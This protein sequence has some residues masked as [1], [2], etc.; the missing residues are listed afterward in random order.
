MEGD[1]TLIRKVA[2]LVLIALAGSGCVDPGPVVPEPM[3]FPVAVSPAGDEPVA[4]NQT[5]SITFNTYVDEAPLT[6]Y[7]VAALS[8]GGVRAF[9]PTR[10]SMVDKSLILQTSRD[11]EPELLWQLDLNPEVLFSVTGQP[12]AGPT[13]VTF[14]VGE[15]REVR[16]E[17]TSVPTWSDVE[18]ILGPCND[19]HAA[20]QWQ[21]TPIT[22][23]GM[24]GVASAQVEHRQIVEAYEPSRSYLMFKLL[25]DYPLRE[26]EHQPPA[27]SD[28][29]A[30]SADELRLVEGWIRAGARP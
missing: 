8:S 25:A 28:M 19:C 9:G 12:Y 7:N 16:T 26:G 20:P 2:G 23:A 22:P 13:T 4:V 27:F 29:S 6:Y 17:E 1:R 5:F 10:W 18:P 30:L 15:D 24:V 21:L 3:L 14:Y 11:M